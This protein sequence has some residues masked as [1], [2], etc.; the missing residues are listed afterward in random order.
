M[1]DRNGN[2]EHS[3]GRE[4]VKFSWVSFHASYSIVVIVFGLIE[5][6]CTVYQLS[7][8]GANESSLGAFNFYSI[9]NFGALMF[10]RLAYKFPKLMKHWNRVDTLFAIAAY[11]F[12]GR[13]LAARIKAVFFVWCL[14]AVGKYSLHF[15]VL[16]YA[17]VG[18]IKMT[19]ILFLVESILFR[20]VTLIDI[21]EAKIKCK[22]PENIFQ[23]Y[24]EGNR[25]HIFTVFSFNFWQI[26]ILEVVNIALTFCWTFLDVFLM[27]LSIGLS[28]AF[29]RVAKRIERTSG[30]VSST[31]K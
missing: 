17:L 5:W 19:L 12:R 18:G 13:T 30:K 8:D 14:L 25:H 9:T 15:F 20:T 27:V 7:V 3:T 21:H 28:H 10:L 4:R 29:D 23:L 24:Y 31:N 22:L 16:G 6:F 11:R 26:P 2:K 1:A